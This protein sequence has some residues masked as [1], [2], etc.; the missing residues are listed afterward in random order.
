MPKHSSILELTNTLSVI[1]GIYYPQGDIPSDASSF[2]EGGGCKQRIRSLSP[3]SAGYYDWKMYELWIKELLDSLPANAVVVDA[4]CGDGRA[5]H[6]ILHNYPNLH[7]V[8]IDTNYEDLH[9][10]LSDLQPTMRDR[11]TPICISVSELD[12]LGRIA[13]ALLCLEVLNV[14]DV[15]AGGYSGI[16]SCLKI[17][18]VAVVST[19]A[20]ESYVVH[21]LLNHD[22]EQV[23]RLLHEGVYVDSVRGQN[24]HEFVVQFLTRSQR[25]DMRSMFG[26]ELL[27]ADSVSG[28]AA[29]LIHSMNDAEADLEKAAVILD[30]DSW[31]HL[32]IPRVDVEWLSCS[33]SSI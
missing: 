5:S 14:M 27:R 28:V 24:T 2:L 31:R 19:I 11:L 9:R 21:A 15:P 6:W 22:F 1:D 4:G 3:R 23:Q 16:A 33:D 26:L 17:G 30:V 12:M 18:G 20:A 29:L 25:N 8:A 10:L 13:D 32:N 7:V